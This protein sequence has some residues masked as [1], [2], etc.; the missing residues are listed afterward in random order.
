M[1]RHILRG[2]WLSLALYV[3]PR[4]FNLKYMYVC[5]C[6]PKGLFSNIIVCSLGPSD[7]TKEHKCF[8]IAMFHDLSHQDVTSNNILIFSSSVCCEQKFTWWRAIDNM[9]ASDTST[10]KNSSQKLRQKRIHVHL[11]GHSWL[12][13][14]PAAS[15]SHTA[16]VMQFPK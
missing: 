14:H 9:L 11:Q 2:F 3:Q 12:E 10:C 8:M 4:I 5:G 1:K 13:G 15:A 16:R 7:Y 6:V